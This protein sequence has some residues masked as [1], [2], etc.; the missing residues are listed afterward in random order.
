MLALW[1]KM[2]SGKSP[3]DMTSLITRIVRYI[4]VMG[5]AEV[6][7][8]PETEA[9][10]YEVG[11]EHFVQGHM[12][13]EGPENSIFMCYHGYDRDIELPCPR[14]SV[15]SVKSLTLQ[16]E[17]KEPAR[18][19]VAGPHTRSRTRR[20]QQAGAGTSRQVPPAPTTAQLGPSTQNMS[21]EEAYGYYAYGDPNSFQAGSSDLRL[22]IPQVCIR[23]MVHR[24]VLRHQHTST[25]RTRSCGAS[26][27][28]R[29]R[30]PPLAHNSSRCR[31]P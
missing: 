2:I 15:Y 31:T 27:T 23:L 9:F 18:R 22:T 5:N 7:F 19:S 30:S 20:D 8:L 24:W 6:T 1:Q 17:K 12:I 28:S 13:R 4:G 16:M 26:L 29:A 14:L 3:I 21:F 25:M 10:G 11:L